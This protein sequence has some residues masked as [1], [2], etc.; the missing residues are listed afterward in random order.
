[1]SHAFRSDRTSSRNR[2]LP[3][4]VSAASVVALGAFLAGSSLLGG[5]SDS[6]NDSG[7]DAGG[8]A[9]AG[10]SGSG[11][12]QGGEVNG[13]AGAMT[14]TSGSQNSAGMGN[15]G[16]TPSSDGGET[17]AGGAGEQP[18]PGGA[19]LGTADGITGTFEG[20]LHTHLFGAMH[21][22]QQTET[23]VIGANSAMYPLLDVWT[24]R[25]LPKLG[26]QPCTGDTGTDDTFISFSSQ[27]NFSAAGTTTGGSCTIDITSLTPKFEG[28]FSA[29]LRTDHGNIAVTD[30]A[31][32]VPN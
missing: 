5:C 25:F 29:T 27:T 14:G 8:Q 10:S 18:D 9:S 31:F 2:K 28:T 4:L 30:G 20:K 22:P 11:N 17:A 15:D 3:R 32:R 19:G 7:D 6:G 13:D 1:M 26:E 24:I 21:T 12:A 16:G 23:S